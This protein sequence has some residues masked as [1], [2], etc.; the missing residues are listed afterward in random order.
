MQEPYHGGNGAGHVTVLFHA[1]LK[2]P[3]ELQAR[4]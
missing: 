2:A 3:E 4:N 1:N